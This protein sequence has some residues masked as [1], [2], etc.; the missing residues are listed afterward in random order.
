MSANSSVQHIASGVGASLG[1]LIMTQT[2]SGKLLHFGIVGW[3]AAGATLASL[4]LAGRV[5]SAEAQSVSAAHLSLAAAAEATADAG[6]G[7]IATTE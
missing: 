3:I 5:R 6:E 7:C 4:Y 2:A 1:G